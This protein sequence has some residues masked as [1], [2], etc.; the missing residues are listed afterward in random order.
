MGKTR[1]EVIA[2]CGFHIE[3]DQF[4][5]DKSSRIDSQT[6]TKSQKGEELGCGVGTMKA[7]RDSDWYREEVVVKH[8]QEYFNRQ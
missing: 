8:I 3:S 1:L 6:C 7:T 4:H 2:L 5:T